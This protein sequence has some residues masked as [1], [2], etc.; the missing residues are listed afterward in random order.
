MLSFYVFQKGSPKIIDVAL[1]EK[2]RDELQ[3]EFNEEFGSSFVILRQIPIPPKKQLD[4]DSE[5]IEAIIKKLDQDRSQSGDMFLLIEYLF[6][7]G[8][9]AGTH[10]EEG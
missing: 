10:P 2:T 3:Q 8:Y 9:D 1:S 7:L 6:K 4:E 5:P